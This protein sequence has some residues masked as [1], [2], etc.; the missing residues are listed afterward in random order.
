[1][2]YLII[3]EVGKIKRLFSAVLA[4]CL[5]LAL[6]P[7]ASA[8]GNVKK[9]GDW[10]IVNINTDESVEYSG[11]FYLSAADSVFRSGDDLCF[12]F[13]N[14]ELTL[15]NLFAP[16]RRMRRFTFLDGEKISE[17]DFDSDGQFTGEYFSGATEAKSGQKIKSGSSEGE[18]AGTMICLSKTPG[19]FECTRGEEVITGQLKTRCSDK[20]NELWG[21]NLMNWADISELKLNLLENPD[22]SITAV[23]E[24]IKANNG[25]YMCCINPENVFFRSYTDFY[26]IKEGSTQLSL[27]N[28]LGD[29]L[30]KF[31]LRVCK[32]SDGELVTDCPCPQCGK[33]QEGEFH[34]LPCGHFSC[35]PGFKPEE[36]GVPEC[37]IA[38]HCIS[39]GTDHSMCKNCREP[40][41]NGKEHGVGICPHVHTWV[42]LSF[43]RPTAT[44]EGKI[45]NKCA[46]CGYVYT[47]VIPKLAQ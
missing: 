27:S 15:K 28:R 1:M 30:I 2:F 19:A 7:P 11:D 31:D 29:E 37:G 14:S 13:S 34:F 9:P 33:N 10:Q 22:G 20:F 44:S 21:S 47:Q 35:A 5:I 46:T 3:K 24:Y 32:N 4:V 26:P 36:H 25:F 39:S 17:S 23:R 45:V 38:G 16:G 8:L 42:T 43:V 40:L 12:T 6:S 18:S 41:C